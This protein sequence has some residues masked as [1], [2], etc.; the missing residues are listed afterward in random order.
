[1]LF[2]RLASGFVAVAVLASCGGGD[3]TVEPSPDPFVEFRVNDILYPTEVTVNRIHTVGADNYNPCDPA[4][5]ENAADVQS[6]DAAFCSTEITLASVVFSVQYFNAGYEPLELAYTGQGFTIHLYEYDKASGIIGDEVWNS[7]YYAQLQIE[8]FNDIGYEL[9]NFDP[10]LSGNVV[11]NP[12]EAFP[13]QNV[14]GPNRLEFRGERLF[15]PGFEMFDPNNFKLTMAP[16]NPANATDDLCNWGE[17]VSSTNPAL[18]EK[19]FCQSENIL[20]LPS[21]DT[22]ADISYL[23]RVRFNYNNWQEQPQDIVITLKAPQQ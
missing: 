21:V 1:M 13:S 22:A 14:S 4:L 17:V 11:L 20:P 7:D 10:N 3:P 15:E 9:D 8:R 16:V 19:V 6:K 2:S 12:G 18:Y 5:F 23:A